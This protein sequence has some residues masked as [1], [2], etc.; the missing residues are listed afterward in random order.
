MRFPA[1]TYA[2][3]GINAAVFLYTRYGVADELS[4]YYPH[5]VVPFRFLR[6]FAT[7]AGEW[8]T[9]VTAM[10][11]HAG[12]AHVLGNMLYLHIFGDNVEDILGHARFLLFY[13]VCGVA[14]FLV[15]IVLSPRSELPNLGASGAVAG[16]LGAYLLLFPRSRV[17]TVVPL[18]ILFPILEV[19]AFLFLG[20]WF[21]LQFLSGAASLG[22]Y[23]LSGGVAWWA[24]VGGFAAGALLLAVFRPAKPRGTAL[25][26]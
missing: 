8:S 23:S 12:W 4:V 10:F 19:P 18:F 15:Q 26:L 22:S 16:V 24:H 21:L 14:S 13:L 11:L 5:A 2:L 6:L 3:I 9:L 20:L 17:L 1:V 7:Q 25:R